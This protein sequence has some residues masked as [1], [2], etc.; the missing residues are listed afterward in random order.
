VNVVNIKQKTRKKENEMKTTGIIRRIDD[1]GRVAIPKEIRRTMGI[2]EGDPLEI[3]T[4]N[5][6]IIFKKYNTGE[7][8]AEL[9]RGII[10]D[11]NDNMF[12]VD[13]TYDN[14]QKVLM[15]LKEATKILDNK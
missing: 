2:H 15:L 11:I 5:D 1:L 6:G 10:I 12:E 8:I 3:F 9:V 13:I 4:E 7:N 14:K